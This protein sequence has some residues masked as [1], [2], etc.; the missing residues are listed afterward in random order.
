[1]HKGHPAAV[2]IACEKMESDETEVRSSGRGYA[3]DNGDTRRLYHG[4]PPSSRV[5]AAC[6]SS[7]I[8]L[9]VHAH[10]RTLDLRP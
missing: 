1:M 7:R 5:F 6:K 3:W 2:Q 9:S 10:F 8:G 4:R